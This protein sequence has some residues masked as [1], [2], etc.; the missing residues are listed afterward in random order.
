MEAKIAQT[1]EV[2]VEDVQISME[3]PSQQA[4]NIDLEELD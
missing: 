1:Q 4:D 2:S 3:T